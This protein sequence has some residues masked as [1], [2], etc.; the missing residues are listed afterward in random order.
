MNAESTK[1]VYLRDDR[2]QIA[3]VFKQIE[4]EKNIP[5]SKN[6][7]LDNIV[8][9]NDILDYFERKKQYRW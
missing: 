2:E 7:Y 4:F 8:S 3:P 1:F 5:S 9:Y 6:T